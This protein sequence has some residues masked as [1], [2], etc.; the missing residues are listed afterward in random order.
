M[1]LNPPQLRDSRSVARV[2]KVLA[3]TIAALAVSTGIASCSQPAQTGTLEG[4]VTK[5]SA[6]G[7][8]EPLA[9]APVEVGTP[10]EEVGKT[11][12]DSSGHYSVQVPPGVYTVSSGKCQ[13]PTPV[14]I[15]LNQTVTQNLSCPP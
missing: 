2:V 12:T 13:T 9:G 7:V 15:Q 8:Q 14:E 3:A 5:A 6:K 4:T 11:S 1:P 10:A